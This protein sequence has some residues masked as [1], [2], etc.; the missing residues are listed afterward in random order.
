LPSVFDAFFAMD[1]HVL[2]NCVAE[3]PM[4]TPARYQS[5]RKAS[6]GARLAAL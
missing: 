4:I 6:T 5:R 2:E 3:N 1:F